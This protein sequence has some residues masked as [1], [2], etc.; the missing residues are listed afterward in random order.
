M[1]RNARLALLRQDFEQLLQLKDPA[2]IGDWAPD[3]SQRQHYSNLLASI[4]NEADILKS[5]EKQQLL[6]EGRIQADF[7]GSNSD[8]FRDK[9]EP[10]IPI[11]KQAFEEIDLER[12]RF[13]ESMERI[14]SPSGGGIRNTF[15]VGIEE[16]DRL[17]ERNPDQE[18]KLF[19]SAASQFL[20]SKLIAFDPDSWLNRVGELAPVRV[21]RKNL[22]L[23]VHVRFRLEE[24]F[25][26]Y[27]F[28]CW[29]SV[30]ALARAVL[31]YAILDNAHK[32]NIDPCWPQ[33]RYG[34]RRKKTLEDLIEDMTAFFPQLVVPMD[35]IRRH[36]NEF[37]HPNASEFS[38]GSLF[39]RE[40]ASKDAL[41]AIVLVTEE[42][43]RAQKPKE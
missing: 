18:F 19:P 41:E 39:R 13:Y 15:E 5:A 16:V 1:D 23:P 42:I 6:N 9:I 38:K 40:K 33:G 30:L 4:L 10:S 3:E 32:F 21:D 29:I 22:Q 37:L 31:E 12:A 27:V 11:L 25:R 43:Y 2:Q 34:K 8:F 24:I 7:S 26:A 20:D 14:G 35:K 17:I 28:G 36:G